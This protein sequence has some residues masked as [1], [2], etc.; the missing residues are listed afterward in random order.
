MGLMHPQVEAD[1]KRRAE[2]YLSC[3][4]EISLQMVGTVGL[5]LEAVL[6]Y[7]PKTEPFPLM[8]NAADLVNMAT[9]QHLLVN[10]AMVVPFTDM[11]ERASFRWC[12]LSSSTST[13]TWPPPSAA[14]LGWEGSSNAGPHTS[15]NLRQRS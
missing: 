11:E 15:M 12:S 6:A 5:R 13:V 2:D 3:L 1:M 8:V 7:D 4:E 9:L 10:N 14:M